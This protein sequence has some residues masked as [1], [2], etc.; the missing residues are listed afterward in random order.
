MRALLQRH[1]E[2]AI[3]ILSLVI[4]ALVKVTLANKFAF[5]NLYYLPVLLA[6]Y[7][8]GR[9]PAIMSSILGVLLALFFVVNWPAE[10]LMESGGR[11]D[12]GLDLLVW[13]SF[14]M[15]VSILVSTLNENRQKRVVLA[16]QE[17]LKK[18]I[19]RSFEADGSHTKR[20]S[21]LATAT[22]R[23]MHLPGD[24]VKQIEAAGLL[25]DLSENDLALALVARPPQLKLDR[26]QALVAGAVPLA[27][28]SHDYRD[29][30][31]AEKSSASIGAKI[32][33]VADLY[34]EISQKL[35]QVQPWWES[36][37]QIKRSGRF[38]SQVI[39][40]LTKA[41]TKDAP[42]TSS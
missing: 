42:A 8:L 20:V 18:Y 6:G 17:L 10:L 36:V 34:D 2:V 28:E 3:I 19:Q 37:E 9:R 1:T 25:H 21:H 5:L 4:F 14:L 22:A 32:L 30:G 24:L 11:L 27:V 40:A 13:A 31:G 41:L 35:S 26:A 38:D 23:Q 7:Y 16:T 33:A 12:L 15:L 39:G 29:G